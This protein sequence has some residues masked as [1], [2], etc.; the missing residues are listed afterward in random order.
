MPS[1]EIIKHLGD[2][3][4]EDITEQLN[5]SRSGLFPVSTGGFGDVYR[6][7]L[8]HG[9]HVGIKCLRLVVH[10]TEESRKDLK[11]AA[12]ELYVWSKCRHPNILELNGV[13]LY[14]NQIAMISPW[15]GNGNVNQ[16][17]SRHPRFDRYWLCARIASGVSYLHSQKIAHGDIKG[18]NILVSDDYIP[19]I[20]DF[21]NAIL[22]NYTLRFTTTTS[23]PSM[24]IRWAAPEILEEESG[25]S[26]EA[27]VYSLGMKGHGRNTSKSAPEANPDG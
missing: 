14:R 1:D 2:H 8:H 11:R 12:H 10:T 17:L 5:L 26:Y 24:S 4:C 27:D 6:G 16:F 15:M 23:G 3:G 22:S 21:G 20:A 13:A 19:K 9:T 7:T 25:F 18:A